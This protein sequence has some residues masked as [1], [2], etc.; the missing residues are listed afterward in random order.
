MFE[1]IIIRDVVRFLLFGKKLM[2]VEVVNCS[3]LLVV[4]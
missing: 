3:I 2:V 4:V 1:V